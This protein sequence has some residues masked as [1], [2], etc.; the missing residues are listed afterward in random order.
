MGN[1]NIVEPEIKQVNL[2]E[3]QKEVD[4][5]LYGGLLDKLEIMEKSGYRVTQKLVDD[6]YIVRQRCYEELKYYKDVEAVR[7]TLEEFKVMADWIR[8]RGLIIHEIDLEKEL[9]GPP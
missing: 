7:I 2:D 3:K 5:A 9:S 4:L 8:K 6:Y 1:S